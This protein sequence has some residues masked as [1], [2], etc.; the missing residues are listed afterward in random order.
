[1]DDF[2]KKYPADCSSEK[3][4]LQGNNCHTMACTS[5]KKLYHQRFEEKNFL[6]KANHPHFLQKSDGRPINEL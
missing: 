6:H 4:I 2:R 5:G 1:M 3:K